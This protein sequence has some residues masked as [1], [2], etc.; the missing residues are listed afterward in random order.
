MKRVK[1]GSTGFLVLSV[2]WIL[3]SLLWFLWIKSPVIGTI[4]LLAGIAEMAIALIGRKRNRD[5]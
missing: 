4:W 3:V 5:R 2:T 1:T